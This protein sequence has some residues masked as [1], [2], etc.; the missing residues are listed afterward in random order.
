ML[1]LSLRVLHLISMAT[2][3]GVGLFT[4]GDIR[5][6]LAAGGDT[7]HLRD[8]VNRVSRVGAGF[9]WLTFLS[10]IGL[11]ISMGGMGAVPVPIHIALTLTLVKRTWNKLEEL[12]LA[13]AS[14]ETTAPLVKRGAMFA[15]IFQT[16]WL[17]NL[18]L[19]VLRHNL[20]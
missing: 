19:M 12:L 17:I 15:G 13:G 16:L 8:R 11:I 5:R 7:S 20:I 18:L 9:G 4:P 1:Y 14:A 3:F 6:P 10:G 2:W